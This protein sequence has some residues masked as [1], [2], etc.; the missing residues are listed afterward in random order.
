M[1]LLL[2][3]QLDA[4]TTQGTAIRGG[5]AYA[6]TEPGLG[7]AWDWERI[8]AQRHNAHTAVISK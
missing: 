6:P 3:H 1:R 5:K 7:I 8:H 4:M 2:D